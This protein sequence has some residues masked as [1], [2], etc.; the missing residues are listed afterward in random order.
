[1]TNLV[2]EEAFPG[3]NKVPFRSEF[4]SISCVSNFFS[5]EK[6][7]VENKTKYTAKKQRGG[8]TKKRLYTK[9]SNKYKRSIKC[10]RPKGFSQKQ[11]CKYGRKK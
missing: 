7:N 9:W 4:T 3:V 2:S 6:E 10:R 8:K 1:M 11:Y 5:C